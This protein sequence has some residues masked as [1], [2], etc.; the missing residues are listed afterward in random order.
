MLKYLGYNVIIVSAGN[1]PNLIFTDA[2]VGLDQ[3]FSKEF[4]VFTLKAPYSSKVDNF[5][6]RTVK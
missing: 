3:Y 4:T 6:P 2:I 1:G 5:Y